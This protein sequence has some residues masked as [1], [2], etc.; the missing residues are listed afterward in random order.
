MATGWLILPG[1]IA[2]L[3]DWSSGAAISQQQI[4]SLLARGVTTVIGCVDLANDE[5]MD[6]IGKSRD[7]PLNWGFVG[8]VDKVRSLGGAELVERAASAAI[9]GLLGDRQN[10]CERGSLAAVRSVGAA[11]GAMEPA[12]GKH[13]R[14]DHV[15]RRVATWAHVFKLLNLNAKRG[16]VGR[17]GAAD[18]A[19]FDLRGKADPQAV[20]D[21]SRL[22]RVIVA[23]ETVWEDG[24]RV[25]GTPGIFLRRD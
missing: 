11:L 19:V 21:W 23:G 2:F 7:L 18:L 10:A 3:E 8:R 6:S 15:P 16:R 14:E 1:Q 13:G 12:C 25:G 20:V 22:G 5:A 4:D 24:K 17:D 9:Q